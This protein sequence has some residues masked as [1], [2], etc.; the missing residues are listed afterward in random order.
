[1]LWTESL[2]FT[3]RALVIFFSPTHRDTKE[4]K[5]SRR[6]S[7]IQHT[8]ERNGK[9]SLRGPQSPEEQEE[10]GTNSLLEE[11]KRTAGLGASSLYTHPL[12]DSSK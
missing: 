7:N 2:A 6:S 12:N 5:G 8:R 11:F 1:M 4:G 3:H 9:D 10:W